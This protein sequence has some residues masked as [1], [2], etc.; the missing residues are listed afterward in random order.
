MI[1]AANVVDIV[2]Y[3]QYWDKKIRV[4]QVLSNTS[5]NLVTK[6]KEKNKKD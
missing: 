2:V 5:G 6:P 1:D 3:H 4:C